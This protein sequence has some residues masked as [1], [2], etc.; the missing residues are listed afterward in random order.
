MA[1]QV[2]RRVRSTQWPADLKV[3][4][5]WSLLVMEL[6]SILPNAPVSGSSKIA[7][8]AATPNLNL[9]ADGPRRPTFTDRAE[10]DEGDTFGVIQIQTSGDIGD[11][12][13]G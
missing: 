4:C 12:P 1:G 5:H 11:L 7:F 3:A 13:A 9:Q 8:L 10:T 6:L 2:G